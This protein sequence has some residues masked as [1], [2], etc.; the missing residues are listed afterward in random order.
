MIR[1]GQSVPWRPALRV[2]AFTLTVCMTYGGAVNLGVFGIL[3]ALPYVAVMVWMAWRWRGAYLKV[4]VAVWLVCGA[5]WGLKHQPTRVFYPA[6]G[7][8]FELGEA[9]CL[10]RVSELQ[11]SWVTLYAAISQAESGSTPV[12]D[13]RDLRLDLDREGP[14]FPH[15]VLQ[16]GQ[17]MRVKRMVVSHPDF[18]E[19]YDLVVDT[20]LGDM[21]LSPDLYRMKKLALRWHDTGQPVRPEDLRRAV[22]YQPSLWMYWAPKPL[23][24]VMALPERLK[25]WR[26]AVYAYFGYPPLPEAPRAWVPPPSPPLL[27]SSSPVGPP[28]PRDFSRSR[29][30]LLPPNDPGIGED[31]EQVQQHL[32]SQGWWARFDHGDSLAGSDRNRNG[33]RDD[34]DD[35]L[36]S[37][38]L[39]PQQAKAAQDMAQSLQ[40]VLTLSLPWPSPRPGSGQ[41]QG[42]RPGAASARAASGPD[43][44]A[45]PSPADFA[46]R[47]SPQQARQ[48]RRLW[49]QANDALNCLY[50]A[51]ALENQA[52]LGRY[53][54]REAGRSS[55]S[56]QA[57]ASDLSQERPST[58]WMTQL[59]VLTAN[60]PRRR[61]H[62]RRNLQVLMALERPDHLS[63]AASKASDATCGLKP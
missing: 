17:V 62:F 58:L 2:L 27:S 20:G 40:R 13:S 11:L 30:A 21:T 1:R 24:W 23:Y 44:E 54:A 47:L 55:G 7:R 18:S 29:D 9:A 49:S 41:G 39:T 37:Q 10:V 38:E 42:Q 34:M 36:R 52:W 48:A 31:V 51:W 59:E 3:P 63:G 50:A 32:T 16:A 60:T 53:L 57:T 28:A 19:H 5:L 61:E 35:W 6:I 25:V 46:Q 12:C 8:E 15:Q 22:F 14:E 33:M 45:T 56:D 4:T 43:G 26:D